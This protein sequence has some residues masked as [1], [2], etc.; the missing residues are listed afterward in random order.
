MACDDLPNQDPV[1]LSD[2]ENFVR[3]PETSSSEDEDEDEDDGF[4]FESGDEISEDIFFHYVAEQERDDLI[5][6]N[7][8]LTQQS[9]EIAAQ[10]EAIEEERQELEE[11][12][13]G[14]KT[15]QDGC[16]AK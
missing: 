12:H 2:L 1:D 4:L 16:Q 14:C 10:A 3:D 5:A 8:A 13:H 15:I 6:E 7:E 11:G 9:K